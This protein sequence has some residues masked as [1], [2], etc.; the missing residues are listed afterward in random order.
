MEKR[1]LNL[2]K[3]AYYGKRKENDVEL[4]AETKRG[5]FSVCGNVWNRTKTDILM[6]GQC[7]DEIAAMFKSNVAAQKLCRLW[8]VFHLY[9]VDKIPSRFR[10]VI[11]AFID[12]GINALFFDRLQAV[13]AEMEV[14]EYVSRWGTITSGALTVYTDEYGEEVFTLAQC[15]EDKSPISDRA[16]RIIA[17]LY[18]G[19][20]AI[21]VTTE[22]NRE[23]YEQAE[24][25]EA[26]A[27]LAEAVETAKKVEYIL[28][29]GEQDKKSV[30]SALYD[31]RSA[32]RALGGWKV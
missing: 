26:R 27:E 2:G 12:S 31:L 23:Q 18:N 25:E 21:K 24:R 9:P 8:S 5:Y 30:K 13:R 11:D 22:S 16:E 3:V 10:R 14:V 32:L 19:A 17:T 7:V 20:P 1:I 15:Y 6:G 4:I 29:A 28:E